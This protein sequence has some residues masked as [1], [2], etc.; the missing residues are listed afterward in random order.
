[1]SDLIIVARVEAAPGQARAL[2]AAQTELVAVVRQQP[3]CITY[4]LHEDIGRAGRV[5]FFERWRDQASWE[6]H[7]R[8]A[9]M[10]AFRAKAGHLIGEFDLLRLKQVA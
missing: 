9:H 3:G 1:M 6:R 2:V 5:V 4:E 8:G 7:M 10:D